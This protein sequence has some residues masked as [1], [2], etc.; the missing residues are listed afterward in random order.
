ME[1][2]RVRSATLVVVDGSGSVRGSLGPVSVAE[3]WWPEAGPVVDAVAAVLPGAAVLRLLRAEP[4]PDEPMGGR[5]TY[6]VQCDTEL[7]P[8]RL[9][10]VGP[11]DRELLEPHPLRLPWARPGGPAAD[12]DWV[13]SVV[14]VIG[15]PRQHKSWNL[16]SI[17]SFPVAPGCGTGAGR[18]WLK[19]VPPFMEHEAAVLEV[20][21]DQPLPRLLA[22]DG[23]RQL[24]AELPGEDGWAAAGAERSEMV[25][26]LVSLQVAAIERV[27]EL[28]ARGVPDQRDEPLA[29]RLATLVDR[30]APDREP[31]VRL[32]AELP[33]RLA[34]AARSSP[35]PTLTHGDPHPGNCRMGT[36]PPVWF[37]WGDATIANPLFD[38]ASGRMG[39]EGRAAGDRAW[40][41]AVPGCD[42]ARARSLLRPVWAL[43]EAG[44]YQ[45]FLDGIEPTER[46]YHRDDVNRMLDEAER[47]LVSEREASA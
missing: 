42:P 26:R 12:I 14:E 33:E 19:S 31:L 37:D 34:E 38:Q 43:R 13:R 7:I 10:E 30:L 44:V 21:A 25:A 5:V 32:A 45:A 27:D 15:P 16:S 36:S 24:L 28:L 35:P 29:A 2:A 9:Q 4:D 40:R 22:A 11:A 47:L 8:G 23:H 41:Q 1:R 20:L 39:S 6:V 17:W 46:I 18:V 3:P